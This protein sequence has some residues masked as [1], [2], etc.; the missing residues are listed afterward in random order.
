METRDRNEQP[1]GIF[2]PEQAAFARRV[3]AVD[4]SRESGSRAGLRARLLAQHARQ[5][6]PGR[7][8]LS[9]ALRVALVA[10][11]AVVLLLGLDTLIRRSLSGIV[12]PAAGLRVTRTPRVPT[13]TPTPLMEEAVPGPLPTEDLSK[14]TPLSQDAMS[15]E[16]MSCITSPTWDSLWMQGEVTYYP[17]DNSDL[18]GRT[19]M[20]AQAWLQKD[21]WK[22]AVSTDIV[23]ANPL[24]SYIDTTV[25]WGWLSDG[26]TLYTYD[27]QADPQLASASVVTLNVYPEIFHPVVMLAYPFEFALRSS[28]PQ[29]VMVDTA[30]GPQPMTETVAGRKAM[31]VDWVLDRLW[32]DEGTGL[33]LRREHYR[34]KIGGS[35]DYTVTLSRVLFDPP[36]P[37][38][39]GDPGAFPRYQ[40]EPPPMVTDVQTMEQDGLTVEVYPIGQPGQPLM[41]ADELDGGARP[42]PEA[43]FLRRARWRTGEA[44]LGNMSVIEPYGYRFENLTLYRGDQVLLEHVIPVAPL[45]VDP[46]DQDFGLALEVMDTYPT[47]RYFVFKDR[48]LKVVEGPSGGFQVLD[49]SSGQ[50][51]YHYDYT[52]YTRW[53]HPAP[54]GRGTASGS[55]RCPARSSST[56]SRS[57]SS[58]ATKRPSAGSSWAASHSTSSFRTARLVSPTMVIPCPCAS[59]R[60]RTTSAA[61]ARS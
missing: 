23:S 24:S 54:V 51:V 1:D 5:S 4:F 26:T 20:L 19:M 29:P 59:T 61:P 50:E 3:S 6:R 22:R 2:E 12:Q 16:I 8:P 27:T 10:A 46:Q 43:G 42:V 57:T 47:V 40:S 18:A 45:W 25:R 34:D 7:S 60:C 49:Q 38:D 37:A 15:M 44:Q 21:G 36:M 17:Q 58:T 52:V 30:N 11:L 13:A 33:L 31:V 48:L 55:P 9:L 53:R 39:L 41:S 56:A 32:V 14:P 35:L 28:T